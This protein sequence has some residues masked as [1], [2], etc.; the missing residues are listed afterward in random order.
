MKV[1]RSQSLST[2]Q[3]FYFFL[4]LRKGEVRRT[5]QLLR[6]HHPDETP[7][8]LATR[9]IRAKTGLAALGGGLLN[10]PGLWPGLGQ[11]LKVAGVV[12]ATSIMTRMHLYLILEIALLFGRDI[13]D[14][15]RVGEMVAVVA[16]T[17]LGST[18]PLLLNVLKVNPY[19]KKVN[20]YI[21]VAAGALASSLVTRF[22]GRTAIRYYQEQRMTDLAGRSE[23]TPEGS[24]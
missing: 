1:K 6:S 7:E 17:G 23:A 9:L 16:A 21:A 11:G 22:I 19:I 15:A 18:S 5:V 24:Y 8:Q 2:E 20:P 10:L 14:E 3:F 12:G 13:D 4:R